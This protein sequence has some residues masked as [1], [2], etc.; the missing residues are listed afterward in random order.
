MSN[1][2]PTQAAEQGAG[3]T[4]GPWR[5]DVNGGEDW[6]VDYDGP[7]SQYMTIC[8]GRRAPVAFAVEP[9]AFRDGE[10]EANARL[11]AAAPELLEALKAAIG[12]LEFSQDYHRDLGNED[13]AFAADRLDAARSAIARAQG[14]AA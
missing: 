9:N 1:P 2:T 11:I 5:V 8:G 13:Q 6:S 14:G 12:A 7:S 4:A 3:H 10:I